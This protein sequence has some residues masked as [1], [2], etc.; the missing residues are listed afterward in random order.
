[1]TSVQA[2]V[3]D[4]EPGTGGSAFRDDGSVLLLPAGCLQDSV[5]RFLRLGQRVQ[6]EVRD[7]VVIRV[8]LP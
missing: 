4:W 8:G 6:L 3:K 2:T 5:F 7:G 1:M